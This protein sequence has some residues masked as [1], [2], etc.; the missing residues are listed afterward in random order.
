MSQQLQKN[1]PGHFNLSLP[2]TENIEILCITPVEGRGSLRAFV[3]IKIGTFIISDCR[4]IQEPS[5]KA[6]FS[7]PVLSYKT[8]YGTTQ[9]RT[10]V[11]ILDENSRMKFLKLSYLL[12]KTIGGTMN[13]TQVAWENWREASPPYL[14]E[15]R[16]PGGLCQADP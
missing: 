3:S 1:L 15:G 8:Q 14:Q 11:Q 12:G 4:V 13:R 16:T 7:L 5:K 2:Q 9:Y 6:W 10:L